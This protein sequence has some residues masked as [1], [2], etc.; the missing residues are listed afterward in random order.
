MH[1]DVS[2]RSAKA[3]TV[4]RLY[5]SADRLRLHVS[6]G[7]RQFGTQCAPNSVWGN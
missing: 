1:N 6:E 3:G 2:A 7:G 4:A 5:S